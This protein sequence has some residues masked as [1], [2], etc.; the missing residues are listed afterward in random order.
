MFFIHSSI[1]LSV[2]PRVTSISW[3]LGA[4][5][6]KG[7]HTSF[8]ISIFI[9]LVLVSRSEIAGLYGSFIFNFLKNFHIFFRSG[10]TN[11]HAY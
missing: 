1:H 6:N 3:Q 8:E 9:F 11:L 2:D 10:S 7:V 4:P 5:M